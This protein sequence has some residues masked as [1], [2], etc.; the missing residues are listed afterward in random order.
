M[1]IFTLT[2]K[3]YRICFTKKEL[4]KLDHSFSQPETD[5][6]LNLLKLARPWETDENTGEILEDMD[7]ICDTCQH[8]TSPPVRFKVTLPTEEE[9]IFGVELCMYLMFLHGKAVLHVV[10][11]A[12]RISRATFL[13][14]HQKIRDNP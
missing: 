12:T 13:D 5:K 1:G 6:L 8:Y 4:F 11:I 7:N 9:L 3:R 14:F 10:D 2:G